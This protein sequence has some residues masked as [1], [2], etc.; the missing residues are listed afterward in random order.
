MDVVAPPAPWLAESVRTHLRNR[1]RPVARRGAAHPGVV[2]PSWLLPALAVLLAIAIVATLLIG[3]RALHSMQTVPVRPP[4]LGSGA[5]CP[6]WSTSSS[7]GG[8]SSAV[9]LMSSTSIGWSTGALR[10]VDGGAHWHDVSPAAMRAD[11][12]RGSGARAYPPAY[13]DFFLNAEHAWMARSYSSA[14]SCFDHETVFLTS[15]GGRTWSKSAPIDA[16]VRAD[17]SLQLILEFIDPRH[18]WLMVLGSGRLA[19]DWFVYSTSDGG[20]D[21]QQVANLPPTSSF[22]AVV[23]V[24]Q[25]S[26]YLGGCNNS[27]GPSPSLIVTRDGGRTWEFAPLPQPVGSSFTVHNPV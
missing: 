23:F 1:R 4:N 3:L 24:S 13:S 19:Q 16:P 2:Q 5:A 22:C 8:S 12:P 9:D 20:A 26:G 27:G 14:T 18:G 10:T 7:G 11:A 15:D 6:S 25:T 21:W 17:S